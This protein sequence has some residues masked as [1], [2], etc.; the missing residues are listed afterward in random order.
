MNDR[1]TMRKM[2]ELAARGLG[3]VD[4]YGPRGVTNVTA[5]EIEAMAGTLALAGLIPV[6]PGQDTPEK[7]TVKPLEIEHV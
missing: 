5:L 2:L 3:K 4:V 6:P 7:L 1:F